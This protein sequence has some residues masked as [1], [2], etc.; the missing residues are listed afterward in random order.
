MNCGS[1]DECSVN[2]E[3]KLSKFSKIRDGYR[4]DEKE[5]KKRLLVGNDGEDEPLMRLVKKAGQS[6]LIS[7]RVRFT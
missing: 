2:K 6:N 1:S 4:Q 7:S 3:T 5:E